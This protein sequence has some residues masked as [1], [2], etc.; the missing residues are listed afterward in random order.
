MGKPPLHETVLKALGLLAAFFSLALPC[1]SQVSNLSGIVNTYYNIVEVL[2]AQNAVRVGNPAGLNLEYKVLIIQMKGASINTSNTGSSAWGDTTSLNNAGNY[3][4]NYICYVN[5][6]TAFLVYQMVNSYTAPTGK[7]QLVGFGEYQDAIITDTLR[8]KLWDNATGTGGVLAIDVVGQLTLNAPVYADG[9]GL[10]G[11]AYFLHSASSCSFFAPVGT[12]YAYDASAGTNLNGAYKGESISDNVPANAD[13]GKGPPANGGGG[14][15][16]HNNGGGGGANLS[17][18]GRGGGNS[19]SGPTGCNTANN[20]GL[21]G[22]PLSSWGGKKLFPGGGGGAGHNNNG[23]FP[24]YGGNGG[25]ILIISA[26]ELIGNNYSITANGGPGGRAQGD[27][28]GG[29]GAG[30]TILADVGTYTGNVN[31]AANGGKGGDVDNEFNAGRCFGGGGGGSAGVIYFTGSTPAV[32]ISHTGGL[33][34]VETNRD[35]GCNTAVPGLPG[36]AGLSIPSYSLRQGTVL[37]GDCGLSLPVGLVRFTATAANR[38]V[39]LTW[40]MLHAEATDHFSIERA[41]PG[42]AWIQVQTVPAVDNQLQYSTIDPL[43]S[44]GDY[45]YRLRITGKNNEVTYSP[46]RF[47]RT[48]PETT[49]IVYPNPA[50]DK[51]S[52]EAVFNGVANLQLLDQSGRVI[53]EKKLVSYKTE[54][55]LHSLPEGIYLLRINGATKRFLI[56]R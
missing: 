19:S 55:M 21:G 11:G 16:N 47:V 56:R 4:I 1:L 26:G 5:G 27:G 15:N 37:F 34:G 31:I 9:A 25:G 20:M 43:S 49:F 50:S 24:T 10:N 2:P 18:G 52:V 40:T 23:L 7:V 17:G 22:R 41:L 48:G 45:Y 14:G 42:Q 46:V 36:S 32:T 30:G 8:P 29:G 51:L 35:G 12:A 6:D 53:L 54:L 39:V 44:A 3:E 33:P 13:G 28:A 38:Q